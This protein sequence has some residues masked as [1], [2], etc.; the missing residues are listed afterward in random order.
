MK[1]KIALA[2]TFA[3][4][5][6]DAVWAAIPPSTAQ[7]VANLTKAGPIESFDLSQ[8]ADGVEDGTLN[9]E[10]ITAAYL[11]RIAA[12]DDSGP[13]LNAVIATFPDALDQ[14]RAMDAELRAGTY[15]GPMHGIPILVKDNVEV[16]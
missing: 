5:Q 8:L 12:V 15:R 9:S 6:P 3:L 10:A 16:A 7:A 14:A 11:A 13:T 1:L 2:F 4:A